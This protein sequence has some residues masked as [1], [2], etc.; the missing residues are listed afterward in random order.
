VLE[1]DSL[2]NV[3]KGLRR[4]QE[5]REDAMSKAVLAAAKDA[6][7]VALVP[8]ARAEGILARLARAGLRPS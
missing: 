4:L 8:L 3:G 1:W 2:L 5:A 7:V 6:G